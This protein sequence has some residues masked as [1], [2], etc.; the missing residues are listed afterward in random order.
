[1]TYYDGMRYDGMRKEAQAERDAL[2]ERA[3]MEFD[4]RMMAIDREE[5]EE[6]ERAKAEEEDAGEVLDDFEEGPR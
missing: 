5:Y 3:E 6:E 2:V 1:M 4:E